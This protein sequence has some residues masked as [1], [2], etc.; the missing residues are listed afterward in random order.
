MMRKKD[1]VRPLYKFALVVSLAAVAPLS[2]ATSQCRIK[3]GCIDEA[4]ASFIATFEVF[5]KKCGEIDPVRAEQY[6]KKATEILGTEDAD[7]LRRLRTSTIYAQVLLETESEVDARD[8]EQLHLDCREFFLGPLKQEETVQ[9]GD[10]VPLSLGNVPTPYQQ[11]SKD[12]K[13]STAAL[14]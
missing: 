8:R 13:A 5:E 9:S 7:F 11:K 12:S 3:G 10:G 6:H 4:S 1:T 14:H 2:D